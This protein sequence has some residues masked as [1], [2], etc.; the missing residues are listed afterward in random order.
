[1]I[2]RRPLLLSSHGARRLPL[3]ATAHRRHWSVWAGTQPLAPDPILG[4]TAAFVEDPHPSKVN[5]GQG[6]YR[7]DDGQPY[8]LSSVKEAEDRV[9]AALRD[10]RGNKEYLPIEGHAAFR[11]LSA[12]LV[13]GK[14]SAGL[15]E[16]RV[17]TLQT[18][19]GTGAL[20][21]AASALR[22][23]GGIAEIY[24]PLPTWSNHH[25]IFAAAGL[26]VKSYPYLNEATGTT[27][28]FSAMAGCL[29]DESAVPEGS[30]VLLHA[31][32]HNPTGIDPTPAQWEELAGIFAARRLTA[33]FDS[34]Y[35]GYASG[36]LDAD[37]HAVRTFEAAGVLP[38][39]CQSY[40]KSMGLYGE[41]LG[42]VNFV[43]AT[44][45]ERDALLSQVKQR[46]VRPV[47]S[48]PPL[49]GAQLATEV[50]GDA[51][52]FAQW[53]QEL[54]LMAGRVRR[55]RTELR[56]ALLA[57]GTPAPDGGKWEHI[58]DQIGMFAYT[59]LSAA[60]V[61]AL[62]E[63]HHVYMTRDGRCC[64]AALKP[65]DVDVR[66]RWIQL[67]PPTLSQQASRP[68]PSHAH[69]LTHVP[70]SISPHVWAVPS[71]RHAAGLTRVAPPTTLSFVRPP[72]LPSCSSWQLR[73]LPSLPSILC[74][75]LLRSV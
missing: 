22:Q 52:L 69:V 37:A 4:M 70:M 64:M 51:T 1:M 19:S 49:H 58:T 72:S 36:D 53:Q 16:D 17:A 38:V 47:Y 7:D 2:I 57:N 3:S 44:S 71:G 50:L 62:R 33:L 74:G 29:R 21:V 41:R 45:G 23:V 8:V 5:V 75:G 46:V 73:W 27:L 13:L 63:R 12:E 6:L 25:Q 55:M 32:A 24:V 40:A 59:G 42:A 10:G 20:A 54:Q 61:D 65:G 11:R 31:C 68:R 60:H 28:D 66:S 15:A 30:S 26:A 35:Q 56:E 43:C 67:S 39:V 48:S 34:A 14:S 9:A 18:I